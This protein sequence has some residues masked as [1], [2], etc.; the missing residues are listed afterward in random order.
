MQNPENSSTEI[1]QEQT[2]RR[3]VYETKAVLESQYAF[4][5]RI[6]NNTT[7]VSCEELY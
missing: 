1:I 5:Q 7:T 3:I 6:K 4:S 2:Q